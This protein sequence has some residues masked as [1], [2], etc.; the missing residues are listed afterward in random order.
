MWLLLE[1]GASVVGLDEAKWL[2]VELEGLRRLN[3]KDA[4]CLNRDHECLRIKENNK[5]ST[6]INLRALLSYDSV[7]SHSNAKVTRVMPLKEITLSRSRVPCSCAATAV[8][9]YERL[10]IDPFK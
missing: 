8:R 10:V 2:Q 9:G 1:Y 5:T 6:I 7:D 4:R 3:E